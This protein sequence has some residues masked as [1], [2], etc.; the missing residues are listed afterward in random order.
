MLWGWHANNGVLLNNPRLGFVCT[1][2]T[3]DGMA[4]LEGYYI[5]QEQALEPQERLRF[6]FGEQCPSIKEAD[7]PA[8]SIKSDNL[9]PLLTHNLSNS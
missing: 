8:F 1:G 5:E 6:R 3:V 7:L 2:Q 9:M 4:G